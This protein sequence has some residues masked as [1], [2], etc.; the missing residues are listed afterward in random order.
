[1]G[2]RSGPVEVIAAYVQRLARQ[3]PGDVGLRFLA[4]AAAVAVAFRREG[5][6]ASAGGS[7]A[8]SE[9]LRTKVGGEAPPFPLAEWLLRDAAVQLAEAARAKE[10]QHA[11]ETSQAEH[12]AAFGALIELLEP[13]MLKHGGS[14]AVRALH[15][16]RGELGLGRERARYHARRTGEGSRGVWVD[17]R[18]TRCEVLATVE[19]AQLEDALARN[20]GDSAL[21]AIELGLCEKTV[22]RDAAHYG[23][24][25]LEKRRKYRSR[26]P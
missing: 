16:L 17:F 25:V 22:G 15:R 10:R 5:P 21:A 19:R 3:R 8:P 12:E 18:G 11:I 7:P 13:F 4:R 23:I 24:S 20:R 6:G 26:R 2:A 9:A 1:M 14:D